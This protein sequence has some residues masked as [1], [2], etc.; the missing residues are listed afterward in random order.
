MVI[1]INKNLRYWFCLA[2]YSGHPSLNNKIQEKIGSANRDNVRSWKLCK[3][4]KGKKK[5]ATRL[6]A[7]KKNA[8]I[9]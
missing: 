6:E 8:K 3:L 4:K 1:L 9:N 2:K 7:R 5:I